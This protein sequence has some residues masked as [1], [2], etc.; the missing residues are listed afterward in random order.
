MENNKKTLVGVLVTVALAGICAW[1]TGIFGGV[2]SEVAE[3]ESLRDQHVSRM[4]EMSDEER[5][6]TRRSMQ[7]RV[8]QLDDSQRK[9][10]FESSR[11]VF[12]QMML[13]RMNQF[14]EMPPEEQD[15]RLDQ[16]IDRMEERR[17]DRQDGGNERGRGGPGG[18][19]GAGGRR[20]DWAKMSDAE[21]DQ[22]RKEMLDKTTPEMRAKVDQF[23]D[24]LNER[25]QER[26][27]DPIDGPG[28]FRGMRP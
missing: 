15:E 28:F 21:R 4:E 26:G 13:N 20:G 6:E 19:P 11:P 17:A 9:Q 16:I 18:P 7:A 24:M 27:L 22:K 5:R 25:R 8:E 2:D 14:F 1:A 3:L 10:F 12:Q 23:K